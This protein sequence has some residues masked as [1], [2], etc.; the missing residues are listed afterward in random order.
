MRV[1]PALKIIQMYEPAGMRHFKF[2]RFLLFSLPPFDDLR[3]S[4]CTNPMA[5]YTHEHSMVSFVAKPCTPS[6]QSF[7]SS[8]IE[9]LMVLLSSSLACAR[10]DG[11]GQ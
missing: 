4:Q 2:G 3:I 9:A 11:P 1:T 8:T 6:S 5:I 7:D 10:K